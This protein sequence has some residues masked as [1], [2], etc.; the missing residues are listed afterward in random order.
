VLGGKG[1]EHVGPHVGPLFTGH[2]QRIARRVDQV[3]ADEIVMQVA[4]HGERISPRRRR[5]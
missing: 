5:R 2:H 4:G 3:F 1:L